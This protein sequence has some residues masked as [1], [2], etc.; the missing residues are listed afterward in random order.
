MVLGA[1]PISEKVS[2]M[3]FLMYILFLQLA[4]AHH[5]LVE[6]GFSSEWKI[7]NTSYAMYLAV[8]GSMIHG[9]TVPGSI[10]AELLDQ[11][12]E[13]QVLLVISVD[14]DLALALDEDAIEAAAA[15]VQAASQPVDDFR[16][17]AAYRT[18]MTRVVCQRVIRAAVE[19]ASGTQVRIPASLELLEDVRLEIIAPPAS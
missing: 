12:F 8:L 17:S 14:R 19:R 11:L 6:P 18:E 1:R 5:M 15:A 3:A 16:A 9:M 4:S 2:R 7:F 13:R 10:E